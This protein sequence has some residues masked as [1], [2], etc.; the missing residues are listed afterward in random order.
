MPQTQSIAFTNFAGG[1]NSEATPLNTPEKDLLVANNIV[2]INNGAVRRRK[3]VTFIDPT[4]RNGLVTQ[5]WSYKYFN[6]GDTGNLFNSIG[7]D[8]NAAGSTSTYQAWDRCVQTFTAQLA[9]TNG[10]AYRYLFI[11]LGTALVVYDYSQ[12][13]Y[14]KSAPIY[15]ARNFFNGFH[16]AQFIQ[17]GN[18]VF[19]VGKGVKQL[20][21][22]EPVNGSFELKT[23]QVKVRKFKDTAHISDSVVYFP[24]HKM[25]ED[26]RQ[27]SQTNVGDAIYLCIREHEV[28][29][30]IVP[31]KTETQVIQGIGDSTTTTEIILKYGSEINYSVAPNPFTG[32]NGGNEYWEFWAYMTDSG[33]PEWGKSDDIQDPYIF[34]SGVIDLGPEGNVSF[35]T[36]CCAV[37]RLWVAG[38]EG[39][40]NSVFFSQYVT[41]REDVKRYGRFYQKADPYSVAFINDT[42]IVDT[43]GGE[44]ILHEAVGIKQI[45]PYKEGVLVFG[46]NGV[47]LISGTDGFKPTSYKVQKVSNEGALNAEC[48]V[49]YEDMVV[50]FS[51]SGV[52]AINKKNDFL[53]NLKLD[54]I[55]VKIKTLYERIPNINKENSLVRYNLLEK[56]IYFLYN[57]IPHDWQSVNNK[58]GSGNHFRS[59]LVFDIALQSW[60]ELNLE[61]DPSGTQPFIADMIALPIDTTQTEENIYKSV[62]DDSDLNPATSELVFDDNLEVVTNQIPV[63]Y[64]KYTNFVVVGQYDPALNLGYFRFDLGLLEGTEFVDFVDTPYES[65]FDSDMAFAY[66]NFGDTLR[67]K[68]VPYIQLLFKRVEDFVLDDNEVDTNEGGCLIRVGFDWSSS[69]VN[70]KY[71]E[72]KSCYF[73]DRFNQTM[74]AGL[75]PG[76][77]VVDYKYKV[78]GRGKSVQIELKNDGN[79]DFYVYGWQL[80]VRAFVRE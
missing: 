17:A 79:K 8:D 57:K 68:G 69:N 61:D 80:L 29:S 50:F 41:E 64:T 27:Q 9:Q 32:E 67:E 71:G 40:P 37:G 31:T 56:K 36:G 18:I 38:Y 73:P 6:G 33:A 4:T 11:Q 63:Q 2:L 24:K 20:K 21:Y 53:D 16:R 47:W 39:K 23:L 30:S 43:D 26:R 25:P 1:L 78:R 44:I 66:V 34:H 7:N 49:S 51:Y 45:I 77:E 14:L 5:D 59:A 74:I 54:N 22:L 48:V 65:A 28:D 46:T 55:S 60:Y 75:N 76:S 19:I 70:H 62:I 42:A 13:S 12:Y 15:T 72:F 52:Y 35:S 3:G 58:N 10:K